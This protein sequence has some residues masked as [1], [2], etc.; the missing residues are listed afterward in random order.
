MGRQLVSWRSRIQ[1]Q[2]KTAARRAPRRVRAR[3]PST[4]HRKPLQREEAETPQQ[5]LRRVPSGAPLGGLG[6]VLQ[7]MAFEGVV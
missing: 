4:G 7:N 3:R 2:G 1:A 6:D 5:E